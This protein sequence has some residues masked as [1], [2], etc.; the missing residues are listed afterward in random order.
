[1]DEQIFFF[2]KQKAL[3]SSHTQAHYNKKMD[4]KAA[5]LQRLS[6]PTSTLFCF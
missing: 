5:H 3:M 4:G 2:R 1:M 6:I